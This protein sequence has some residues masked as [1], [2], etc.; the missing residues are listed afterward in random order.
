MLF[1]NKLRKRYTVPPLA[2][3]VL[4]RT[5]NFENMIV[6]EGSIL[7]FADNIQP[8]L[9]TILYSQSSDANFLS[10]PKSTIR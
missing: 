10:H 5:D 3:A 8:F 2:K 7:M 4:F 1:Q 9:V 6:T